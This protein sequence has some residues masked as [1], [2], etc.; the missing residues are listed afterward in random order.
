[1]LAPFKAL[2]ADESGQDLVEYAL[3]V[4]LIAIIV[5]AAL[6][7]LGPII[8]TVFNNISDNLNQV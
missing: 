3:L 8:A 6:R 2:W 7:I 4:A 5:I 1:M